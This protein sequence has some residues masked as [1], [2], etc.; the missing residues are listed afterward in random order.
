LKVEFCDSSRLLAGYWNTTT[1]IFLRRLVPG[2]GGMIN[3]AG[4]ACLAYH[5]I[6]HCFNA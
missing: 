4:T 6:I 3:S 5:F 2:K 1:G